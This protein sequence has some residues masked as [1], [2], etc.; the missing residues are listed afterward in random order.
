MPWASSTR[1]E[2]VTALAQAKLPNGRIRGLALNPVVTA[3]IGGMAVAVAFAIGLIMAVVIA[4]QIGQGESRR[5]W[6]RS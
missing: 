4:D 5:G 2:H 3:E 1:G 6:R